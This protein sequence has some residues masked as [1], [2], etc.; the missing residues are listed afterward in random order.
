MFK[1]LGFVISSNGNFKEH[2][3]ELVRKGRLAAKKMWD[4]EE[5]ICEMTLRGDGI[6]LGTWYRV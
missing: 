1:Y 4:L 5:R 6:Y 3:K 2:L